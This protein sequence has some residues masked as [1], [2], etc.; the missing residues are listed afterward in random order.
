MPRKAKPKPKPAARRKRPAKPRNDHA[1]AKALEETIAELQRM[2][3]LE[4]IDAAS[5]AALRSMAKELDAGGRSIQLWKAYA[6]TLERLMRRDDDDDGID[7]LIAQL[8]AD[9]GNPPQT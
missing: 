1:N 4:P 7:E 9:P 3:R 2:G 5:I 8:S 6:E